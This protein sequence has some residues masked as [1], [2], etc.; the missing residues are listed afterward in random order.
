MTDQEFEVFM[1]LLMCSDPWPMDHVPGSDELMVALADKEAKKRGFEN[2][3][4]A[5][6]EFKVPS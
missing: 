6:H 4:V 3:I 5:L 1:G 2:W